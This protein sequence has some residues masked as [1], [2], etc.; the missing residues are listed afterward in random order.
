MH[1]LPTSLGVVIFSY[2]SQIFLPSLEANM[3]DRSQFPLMMRVTHVA[4]AIF[5]VVFAYVGFVTFGADTREVITNNLPNQAL[6]V[7]ANLFLLAK[8]LLSYPLPYFAAVDLLE[9]AF[10]RGQPNTFFPPC[11]DQRP[12]DSG[13]PRLKFWALAL[14][15]SLIVITML[16]AIYVPYF[17]LLVGVI[18]NLT[19]NMLTLVWPAYFHLRIKSKSMGKIT[20]VVD[21]TIVL[22]GIGYCFVGVYF[23]MEHLLQAINEGNSAVQVI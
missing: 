23:S 20:R 6:R 9:K 3:V 5:K 15:V 10:F 13:G 19:A 8:C 1:R 21:T 7:I 4:A 16:V 2:T 12:A 17:R 11:Y 22:S 18:G 14:R